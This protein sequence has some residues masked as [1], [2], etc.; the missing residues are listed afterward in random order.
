M[1][2]ACVPVIVSSRLTSGT[3]LPRPSARAR[4]A[5][6]ERLAEQAERR[7]EGD[8]GFGHHRDG[9]W[10]DLRPVLLRPGRCQGEDV[11]EAG[12]ARVAGGERLTEVESL[13]HRRQE[14]GRAKLVVDDGPLWDP[15]G[16]RQRRDAHARAVEGEAHLAGCARAVG[17]DRWRRRDVVVGAAVLVEGH[18]QRRVEVV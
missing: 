16:D 2:M 8:E 5:E 13:A 4:T 1:A 11:R 12:R 9:A 17:R 15:R 18:Q 14:R 6:Q 10:G 3:V 7:V